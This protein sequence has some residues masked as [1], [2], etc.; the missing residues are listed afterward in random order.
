MDYTEVILQIEKEQQNTQTFILVVLIAVSL[1]FAASLC[2]FLFFKKTYKFPLVVALI[3]SCVVFAFVYQNGTLKKIELDLEEEAFVTYS[4]ACRVRSYP[5]GNERTNVYVT[6][7]DQKEITL[8]VYEKEFAPILAKREFDGVL[9][10]GNYV[11]EVVYA[12]H[13]HYVV[14]LSLTREE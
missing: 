13:S 1:L 3:L 7:E 2:A 5:K 6:D 4:G 12:K 9:W 11:G 8:I 14:S 10:S